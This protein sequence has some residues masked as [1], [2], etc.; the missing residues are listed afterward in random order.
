MDIVFL[1]LALAVGLLLPMRPAVL[2]TAGLW[3][4]AVAM[5]AWGPAHNT[6]VHTGSVGFWAPWLI[7]G[8]IGEGIT[9]A[10]CYLRARRLTRRA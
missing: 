2:T 5:V 1:V 7:C 6:N 3:A 9:A 10:V 8:L 4:V